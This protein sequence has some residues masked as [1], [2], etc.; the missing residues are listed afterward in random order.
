MGKVI[1]YVQGHPIIGQIMVT[2]YKLHLPM[3][4]DMGP[5]GPDAEMDVVTE[6]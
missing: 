2:R 5:D 4:P 1:Y 3:G 6:P